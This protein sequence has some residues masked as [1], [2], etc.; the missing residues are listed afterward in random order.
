[1]SHKKIMQLT[2]V[3]GGAGYV[4]IGSECMSQMA[5]YVLKKNIITL[6]S[7]YIK[8]LNGNHDFNN[9]NDVKNVVIGCI[10]GSCVI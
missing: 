5:I 2:L 6:P 3:K 1:M 4:Y 8:D 7:I 9:K 10:C